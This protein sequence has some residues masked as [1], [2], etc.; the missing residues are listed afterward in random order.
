MYHYEV[1]LHC[2]A[3]ANV[4]LKIAYT[5]ETKR[6]LRVLKSINSRKNSKRFYNSKNI[7]Y[8]TESLAVLKQLHNSIFILYLWVLFLY[9]WWHITFTKQQI[10]T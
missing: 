5:C 4:W 8:Q 2:L 10:L 3:F 6:S 9:S 1:F 7:L